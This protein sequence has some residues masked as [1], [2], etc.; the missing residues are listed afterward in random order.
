MY[1][2]AGTHVAGIAAANFD[3]APERNGVAPGAQVL[4]CKI[5][6]GRLGSAETG[7]GLV[8]ALIAAKAAGCDLINLSYGEPFW[9]VDYGRTAQTFIDAVRKWNMNVFT[10][11]GNDGPALSSLGS[12]GCLSS[13]ITVGAYV[14][15]PMMKVS[16][17]QQL[18]PPSHLT[19]HPAYV[20]PGA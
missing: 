19:P 20:L 7:T 16:K 13:L 10:S 5:G 12:P 9:Q 2:L 6:D 8:R 14:S 15:P 4:A 11:A 17:Q 3:E 18:T 1:V